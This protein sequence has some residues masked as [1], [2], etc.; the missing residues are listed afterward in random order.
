MVCFYAIVPFKNITSVKNYTCGRFLAKETNYSGAR[1]EVPTRTIKTGNDGVDPSASL[2]LMPAAQWIPHI[3]QF[4]D[5]RRSSE[6]PGVP[7]V[8]ASVEGG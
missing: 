6:G 5:N 8:E 7:N 4:V 1:G 3:Q 2:T